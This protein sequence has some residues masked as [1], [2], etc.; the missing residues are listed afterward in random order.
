MEKTREE[1]ANKGEEAEEAHSLTVGVRYDARVSVLAYFIS[2]RAYGTWLHGHP[3]GSVDDEHNKPDTP[4]L[5]AD[6]ARASRE[7]GALKHP[8]VELD[9][10]RRFVV[11]AAI[12]SVCAHRGWRL[13]A[14]HVRSTHVHVVVSAAPAPERVMNDFKAWS[15]RR[16][17]EAGALPREIEPWSYH[18]STRYLNTPTSLQRAIDYTLHEQGPALPMTRPTGWNDEWNAPIPNE[19]QA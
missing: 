8:P 15:T 16:M 9:A 13:R 14:L 3:E 10:E 2:F 4:L 1:E 5:P 18:G 19:P 17:R 7:S 6:P 12:R 11:D